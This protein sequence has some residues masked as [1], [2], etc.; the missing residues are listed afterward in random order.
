MEDRL[1]FLALG[2]FTGI[3]L[4]GARL[5]GTVTLGFFS[6]SRA[7]EPISFWWS[8]AI[9]SFLCLVALYRSLVG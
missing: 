1:A 8:V 5:T 4:V 7:Q 6:R 3:L 2:V 9:L